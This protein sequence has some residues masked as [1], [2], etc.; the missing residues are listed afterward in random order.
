MQNFASFIS[1][2][3]ILLSTTFSIGFVNHSFLLSFLFCHWSNNNF[4]MS[5]V[6]IKNVQNCLSFHVKCAIIIQLS[7][8]FIELVLCALVWRERNVWKAKLIKRILY[9]IV[10]GMHWHALFSLAQT[11]QIVRWWKE[12]E[13]RWTIHTNH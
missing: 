12:I 2:V 5:F 7:W 1:I 9:S 8:G 6:S 13:I 4:I 3:L 11:H 10:H